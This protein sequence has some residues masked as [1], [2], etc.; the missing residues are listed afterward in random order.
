MFT[1]SSTTLVTPFKWISWQVR[2]M[3]TKW[4]KKRCRSKSQKKGQM[5]WNNNSCL[6]IVM[7]LWLIFDICHDNLSTQ[8]K[9]HIIIEHLFFFLK[10]FFSSFFSLNYGVCCVYI[11]HRSWRDYTHVLEYAGIGDRTCWMIWTSK[12]QSTRF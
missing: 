12:G 11:S 4:G 10:I 3:Y 5:I 8:I 6:D 2:N 7:K 1:T 9:H